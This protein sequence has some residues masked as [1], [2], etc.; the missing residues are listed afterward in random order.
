M[1]AAITWP[2]HYIAWAPQLVRTVLVI[3]AVRAR[4]GNQDKAA[5]RMQLP[6][7]VVRRWNRQ[8][9]DEIASGLRRDNVSMSEKVRWSRID[10]IHQL[11]ER[12]PIHAAHVDQP[13]CK[14]LH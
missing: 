2:L 6:G 1:E 4:G 13:R 12:V 14:A 8:G 3:A 9:L 7:R 10:R 5:R 11:R